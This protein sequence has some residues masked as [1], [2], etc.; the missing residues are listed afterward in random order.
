MTPETATAE[1]IEL[2]YHSAVISPDPWFQETNIA[3]SIRDILE[4]MVDSGVA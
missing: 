1:I 3:V 2:V 4:E